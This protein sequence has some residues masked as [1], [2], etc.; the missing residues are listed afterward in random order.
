M[1]YKK[2][3]KGLSTVVTTLI[4]I[5]LVLV[6]I[7]IIWVVIRGLIDQSSGQ[8]DLLTACPQVDVSVKSVACTAVVGAAD[9]SDCLVTL[10][11]KD[12]ADYAVTN[13]KL[14]F[15]NTS[16][17]NT[18]QFGLG[19]VQLESKTSASLNVVLNSISIIELKVYPQ[20]GDA[21]E[22]CNNPSDTF[23]GPFV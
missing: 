14:V 11:R 10:E 17:S 22:I 20:L 16:K 23:E 7:G 13:A 9:T 12:S 5:L 21:E 3:K 2:D 15:S 1:L 6:A 8:I 18:V 19:L 4:I